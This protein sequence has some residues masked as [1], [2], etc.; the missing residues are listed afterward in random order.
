VGR[1]VKLTPF[2]V[3]LKNGVSALV[4]E[5]TPDDRLLLLSGFEHLSAQSKYFR[6][7]SAGHSLSAAEL[8]AFTAPNDADHVAIGALIDNTVTPEPV[9]IARYIRLPGQDQ[10]AEFAITIANSH[11]RQGLGSLL[12]GVLAK[13]ARLNG[14]SEFNA[15]VHSENVSMLRLL[16]QLG[17]TRVRLSSTEIEL[18]IPLS[19]DVALYSPSSV[20]DAF[21]NIDGRAIVA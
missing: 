16:S 19:S 21:R 17:G 3:T 7:L 6:F 1:G 2:S 11:Q 15:L 14:I 10:A 4:R 5:V 9:G 18:K 8:D 13:M 20:G 12:L